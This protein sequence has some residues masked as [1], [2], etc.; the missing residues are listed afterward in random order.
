MLFTLEANIQHLQVEK[1]KV[2]KLFFAFGW[3][4][5]ISHDPE[6]LHLNNLDYSIAHDANLIRV[7]F[8]V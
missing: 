8:P 6:I 5:K 4:R 3:K 1:Q 7:Q 2:Y